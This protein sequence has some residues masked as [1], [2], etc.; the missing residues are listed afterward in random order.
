MDCIS[1]LSHSTDFKDVELE[2]TRV[3]QDLGG[4]DRN[5]GCCAVIAQGLSVFKAFFLFF[6]NHYVW[7]LT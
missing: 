7:S 2:R 4:S 5:A 3:V 1:M 6:F